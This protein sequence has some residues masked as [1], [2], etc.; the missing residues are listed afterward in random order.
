MLPF[1]GFI[2]AARLFFA[3][4]SVHASKVQAA[5]STGCIF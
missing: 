5:G 4:T 2:F 1:V 3:L